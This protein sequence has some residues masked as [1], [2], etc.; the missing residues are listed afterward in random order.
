MPRLKRVSKEQQREKKKVQMRG[1]RKKA[2]DDTASSTSRE[3]DGL[4]LSKKSE[5]AENGLNFPKKAECAENGLNFPKKSESAENGLNFPRKSECAEN[6]LNFPKKSE[7]A[8]KGLNFPKKS[9]CDANDLLVSA[10]CFTDS[11]TEAFI[12]S[13]VDSDTETYSEPD[14][15]FS[16]CFPFDCLNVSCDFDE[17]FEILMLMILPIDIVGLIKRCLR[18]K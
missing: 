6:G 8:E 2:K 7:C 14:L 9:Q 10:K 4:N 16:K 17:T 1:G 3:T 11:V 13:S 12:E 5:C 15:N 18:M